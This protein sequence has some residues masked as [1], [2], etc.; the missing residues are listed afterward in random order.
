MRMQ[1]HCNMRRIPFGAIET[2][3]NT[4]SMIL[5]ALLLQE[6]A[7]FAFGSH[8][9]N[10]AS[11]FVL[12]RTQTPSFVMFWGKSERPQKFK[13]LVDSHSMS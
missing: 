12:K 8:A 11:L 6:S 9:L 3:S 2:A 7:V 13:P 1:F 5:K 10:K 4:D